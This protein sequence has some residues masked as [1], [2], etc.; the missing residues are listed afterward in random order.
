ML[1]GFKLPDGSWSYMIANNGA[2]SKK[3]AITNGKIDRPDS[4]SAYKI[5]ESLIPEDRAVVLPDAYDT[6]ETAEGVAYV[7]LP[8]K[9]F[10][11]L[12]NKTFD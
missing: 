1:I 6:I 5:T 10:T 3:I 7:T 8:A 9:S 2:G 11:V 12:S 4:M